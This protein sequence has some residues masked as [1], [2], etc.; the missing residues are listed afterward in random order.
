MLRFQR[1][2]GNLVLYPARAMGLRK[3]NPRRMPWGGATATLSQEIS[4]GTDPVAPPQHGPP[5]AH[6]PILQLAAGMQDID[7]NQNLAT[8]GATTQL[9]FISPIPAKP[10]VEMRS[11]HQSDVFVRTIMAGQIQS[12]QGIKQVVVLNGIPF[13]IFTVK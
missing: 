9:H 10:L 2:L 5:S 8:C 3:A 7:E 13:G 4:A 11:R 1:R 12:D 6:H